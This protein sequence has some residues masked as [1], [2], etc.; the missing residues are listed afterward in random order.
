MPLK[1]HQSKNS[2]EFDEM[3]ELGSDEWFARAPSFVA[4]A[5]T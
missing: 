1:R 3:L 4:G 5:G 2:L